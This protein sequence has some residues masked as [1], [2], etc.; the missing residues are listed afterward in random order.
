MALPSEALNI[1]IVTFYAYRRMAYRMAY[2]SVHEVARNPAILSDIRNRQDKP[3][4][5]RVKP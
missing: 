2:A 3:C 5:P 1:P 4:K